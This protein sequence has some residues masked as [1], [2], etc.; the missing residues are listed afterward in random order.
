MGPD[1]SDVD[2]FKHN[3]FIL[4]LCSNS[5]C[6]VLKLFQ[7]FVKAGLPTRLNQWWE[8]IPFLTSAVVFVCGIIYLVCLLVGYDS[9]VEVCFLPSAVVS[10]F[11]GNLF[12]STG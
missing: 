4:F 6:L 3:V 10:H 12:F 1:F 8:G 11:Q 9:F 7:L 2:V 5:L